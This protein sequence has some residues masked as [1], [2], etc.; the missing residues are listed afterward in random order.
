M[1]KLDESL[2]SGIVSL[3]KEGKKRAT[4][5]LI[6]YGGILLGAVIVFAVIFIV[7]TDITITSVWD[8]ASLGLEFFLLLFCAYAMYVGAADSGSRSGLMTKEFAEARQKFDETKA[9]VIDAGYQKHLPS[10]CQDYIRQELKT[11]RATILA[12][13]GIDYDIYIEKYEKRDKGYINAL[14]DE[15]L[16]QRQKKAVISANA[17]KPI[18]LTPDMIMMRD[19]NANRQ[20]PL[21]VNPRTKKHVVFGGKFITTSVVSLATS[22][23]VLQTSTKPI[24]V[25]IATCALKLVTIIVNGFL[26]YKMGYENIAVDAVGYM[27][28]QTDLMHQAIHFCVERFGGANQ[29]ADEKP[30]QGFVPD[31]SGIGDNSGRG[32]SYEGTGADP[33][34]AG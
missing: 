23:I 26:G 7:S 4:K 22:A 29:K 27:S 11:V 16:S 9:K 30:H 15:E 17:V 1:D 20:S 19:T 12:N 6:N 5:N 18:R 32:E 24:G 8:A 2:M 3:E 10:F 31:E 21:G 28:N 14:P 13:V 33:A 34:P 25:I